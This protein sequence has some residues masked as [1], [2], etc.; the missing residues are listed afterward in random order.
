MFGGSRKTDKDQ[1]LR[2]AEQA[3]ER[4]F[5]QRDRLRETDRP[6]TFSEIEEEAVREGNRLA[7]VLLES[8]ISSE[9]ETSGCHGEENA[10]PHCGKP[11]KRKREDLESREL[12]ARPGAVLFGRYQYYCGSCRRS[13]F[14]SGSPA[15][16]QG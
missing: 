8:K 6:L 5:G 1:W 16:P 4:V 13:F 2:E 10:C 15:K 3:Y 14:P 12:H 7:R 9:T 11:A